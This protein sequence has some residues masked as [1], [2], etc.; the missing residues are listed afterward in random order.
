MKQMVPLDQIGSEPEEQSLTLAE[1]A[2]LPWPSEE[3]I[4]AFVANVCDAHSWYKH[5]SLRDGGEFCFFLAKDAGA[6]YTE[7]SPRLHYGWKT[8]E[9]YRRRFGFLDYL[10]P[11]GRDGGTE[12]LTLPPEIINATRI[13]LFPYVCRYDGS[14]ACLWANH[15]GDVEQLLAHGARTQAD[16]DALRWYASQRKL[17]S[18]PPLT[19]AEWAQ[20]DTL[21]ENAEYADIDVDPL[22]EAVA[23]QVRVT[24]EAISIY[25][26]L[27]EKEE[28]KIRDAI[29]RLRTLHQQMNDGG[30]TAL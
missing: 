21:L 17:D 27:Q 7:E 11:W 18:L 30:S 3:Q 1:F 6:G 14:E 15:A 2:S 19:D 29:T 12:W 25:S 22:P 20:L 5:L 23:E 4:E 28:V 24:Q 10:G 16:E 9:E 13:V 26:E 8:T